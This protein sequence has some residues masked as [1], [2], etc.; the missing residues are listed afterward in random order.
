MLLGLFGALAGVVGG[1]SAALLVVSIGL[2]TILA[3]LTIARP[4]DQMDGLRLALIVCWVAAMGGVI[5][6][7]TWLE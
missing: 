5:V 1:A 3:V 2:L 4:S 6:V 7:I